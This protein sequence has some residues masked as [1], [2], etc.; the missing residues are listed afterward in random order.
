ML[1]D[2]CITTK[3]VYTCGSFWTRLH[4]RSISL[5]I[6]FGSAQCYCNMYNISAACKESCRNLSIVVVLLL[7]KWNQ[8]KCVYTCGCFSLI[9]KRSSDICVTSIVNKLPV[10]ILLNV[11]N[12]RDLLSLRGMWP[13][14]KVEQQ[15]THPLPS[16]LTSICTYLRNLSRVGR[17][18][19]HSESSHHKNEPFRRFLLVTAASLRFRLPALLSTLQTWYAFIR[20]STKQQILFVFI[21]TAW[22]H[23]LRTML[24]PCFAYRA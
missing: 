17:R 11:Y 5:V 4:C 20:N 24:L 18:T 23:T 16:R 10:V 8:R 3:C 9:L 1:F 21:S 12:C 7:H 13:L 6:N 15:Q 14:F 2:Y 19:S 22:N